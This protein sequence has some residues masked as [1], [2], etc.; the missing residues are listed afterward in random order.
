[1]KVFLSVGA[2]YSEAQERFVSAFESFLGQN[3]CERL[4]VGRGNYSARQPILQARDLMATADAVVVLAFTRVEVKRAVERPDS[5]EAKEVKNARYPTVW[6][7]LEAAMA[8]GMKIP[9]LV[10]IEEGLH[11]E[12][13]LKDRLEF[14]ALITPLEPGY[15]QTSEFK[16][17]FADFKRIASECAQGAE[18]NRPRTASLTVADLLRDLRPDQIWK[19]VAAVVGLLAAVAAAAYWVGKHL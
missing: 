15:F 1:M 13:M 7:Q 2:T 11:R 6:N 5:P 16:G 14:R 3:G 4:T 18:R 19:T 10:I 17:I 8:F 9:L 12:A